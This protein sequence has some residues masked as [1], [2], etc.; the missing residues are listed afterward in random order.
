MGYMFPECDMQ[1]GQEGEGHS[2]VLVF[3][4]TGSVM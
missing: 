2:H 4:C 3:F 1:G